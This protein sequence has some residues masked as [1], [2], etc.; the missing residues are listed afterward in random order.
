MFDT[1]SPS[2]AEILEDARLKTRLAE[3]GRRQQETAEG[4]K[5]QHL[6]NE[7][8]EAE[9]FAYESN[10]YASDCQR[11]AAARAASGSKALV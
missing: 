9:R 2:T 7:Q 11:Y 10:A 1:K 5:N 4:L 6:T 3:L 8:I